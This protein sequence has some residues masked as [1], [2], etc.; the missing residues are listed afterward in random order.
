MKR[1]CC[2][3]VGLALFVTSIGC[4]NVE[5]PNWFSPG[6]AQTQRARA[7]YNDPYPEPET[8]PAVVGARPMEYQKPQAEVLRARS[9]GQSRGGY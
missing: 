9:G 8:G 6:N 1:R 2:A 4:R 3:I 5:Y 7:Q